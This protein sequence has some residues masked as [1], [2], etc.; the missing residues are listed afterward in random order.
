VGS[1]YE[2]LGGAPAV[3]A[4]VD[5]FYRRVLADP[6]VAPY[7]A[8]SDLGRLE[9]HQRAFLAAA[10]GGP[11]PYRGRAMRV[12]H[13]GRGITDEAFDR[14]ITHLAGTLASLGVGEE[15]IVAVATALEPLR[16]EIVEETVVPIRRPG[17]AAQ[18]MP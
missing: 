11:N 16:A 4:A 15:L 1:M 2:Q 10:L 5:E 9:R 18:G 7:F 12:A 13:A 6:E 14:V 17:T 8:G 3:Q